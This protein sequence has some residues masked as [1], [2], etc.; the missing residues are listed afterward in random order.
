MDLHFHLFFKN[1]YA[2]TGVKLYRYKSFSMTSVKI[3][4]Q[5]HRREKLY[6]YE[7]C[8]V[9]FSQNSALKTPENTLAKKK[10]ILLYG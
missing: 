1:T 5:A 2:N 6:S 9:V 7:V 4:I 10:N 3:H 8:G